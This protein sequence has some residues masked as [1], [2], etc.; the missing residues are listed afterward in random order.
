MSKHIKLCHFFGAIKSSWLGLIVV[1][2]LSSVCI[3]LFTH[4]PNNSN[5][6][7]S[8]LIGIMA[9]VIA[10]IIYN[11]SNKYFKSCST[12]MWILDQ[13]EILVEYCKDIKNN[14]KNIELHQFNIWCEVVAIREKAREL[15]FVKEFNKLS[16][17][18]SNII[19][20]IYG[21]NKKSF[22]TA[23]SRLI[24]VQKEITT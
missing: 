22:D 19:V 6:I 10:S 15:T 7:A 16:Y 8:F 11:V 24:N 3:L 20:A 14:F 4:N 2:I 5:N 1:F 17:E 9:S 23:L 18:F 12:Y 13:T 21:N